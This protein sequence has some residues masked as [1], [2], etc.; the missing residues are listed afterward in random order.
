MLATGLLAGAAGTLA[1]H[2]YTYLDIFASARPPSTLPATTVQK[3]A[4]KAGIAVLAGP[5]EAAQNRRSGAGALLGYGVGLGAGV[6]YAALRPACEAWL[7]WPL[8]GAI[9]GA[10][11]L[12]VSEGSATALGATDWA[13]WTPSEWLADII[14]RT[15][16]GLTVAYV[17]ENLGE[18]DDSGPI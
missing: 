3:L 11:T 5:A 1:L 18:E 8:A 10:A 2:L 14:P 7:P 12:V 6:G 16:Y 13:Q 17:C 15:L 4:E 9:L